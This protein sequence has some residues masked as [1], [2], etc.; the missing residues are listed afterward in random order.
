MRAAVPVV[1]VVPGTPAALRSSVEGGR[2]DGN[3]P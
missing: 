3:E 1:L 2:T